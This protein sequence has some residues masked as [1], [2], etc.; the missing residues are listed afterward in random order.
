MKKA[1]VRN[2]KNYTTFMFIPESRSSV[3]SF[4]IPAWFPGF[5]SISIVILIVTSGICFYAL[6]ELKL[7]YDASRKEVSEL[8]AINTSQKIEIDHLQRSSEK[9][10]MQLAENSRMLDEVKKTVGINP[11]PEESIEFMHVTQEISSNSNPDMS[12]KIASI[13]TNFASLTEKIALQKKI[14]SDSLDPIKKQLAYL[15]A[16]PSI[17][18][19]TASITAGFGYRKNPFTSRGSEFHKGIDFAASYGQTV[20]ASGDG[21]VAFSGWNAGYGRM[22][23]ISHGYGLSSLYAHNSKLLVKQ[24]DKVKK[25][26]AISKVGNTGRS[27]GTHLHYEV[28]LNGKNV[29]PA[30]YFD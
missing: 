22:V 20:S 11:S 10:Q 18:P 21:I 3:K 6:S 30:N 23:I 25:G 26:Q 28:K 27:T 4:R 9:I 12:L 15:M 2:K 1:L 8:T 29:N 17:K 5:V 19:V 24:G 14:I 16:K 7:Q 13:E